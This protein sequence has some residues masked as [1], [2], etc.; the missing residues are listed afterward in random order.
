MHSVESESQRIE[1]FV[2]RVANLASLEYVKS[3]PWNRS[4]QQ[5]NLEKRPRMLK[6]TPSKMALVGHAKQCAVRT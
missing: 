6:L 5:W 4:V 2:I 3:V 1:T